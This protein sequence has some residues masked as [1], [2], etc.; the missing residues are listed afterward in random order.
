MSKGKKASLAEIMGGVKDPSSLS[1]SKLPELLGEAMPNLPR[2]P[3]GRFRL[4][5]ALKNRFGANFRSLPG[6]SNL[7]REFDSDIELEQRI[8]KLRSIKYTPSKKK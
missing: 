3:V 4:V 2:N 5:A 1:L 8:Q 7:V 6:V